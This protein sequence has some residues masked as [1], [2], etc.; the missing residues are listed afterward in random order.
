MINIVPQ[1]PAVL[2]F[3][4]PN[5]YNKNMKH[6]FIINSISG[7]GSGLKIQDMIRKVAEEKQLDHV[8]AL[9][10]RPGHAI[11]LAQQYS[12]PDNIIYCVGGDGT[13]WEVL[14]GIAPGTTLG[15]IPAGSG[16]DFYRLIGPDIS[17]PE[18]ILRD[19]IDAPV[20]QIDIGETQNM[21]F[22][23]TTSFGI[24]ADVNEYASHLIR[25]TVITKG[26]AYIISIIKNLLTLKPK[27]IRINID[28]QE[29]EGNYYIVACMNGRYYGNGVLPAPESDLQDGYF[30]LCLLNEI[31]KRKTLPF[32]ARYMKGKH[33]GYP[34]FEIIHAK[35]IIIDSD[36]DLSCQSDG[37]NYTSKHIELHMKKAWLNLKVPGYLNIIR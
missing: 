27:H 17:D 33:L 1:S 11:Q 36:Q 7:K 34:G 4:D 21:R 10:E 16:N 28:G 2:N 29:H 5:S 31:P 24:D 35:D 3:W 18:K 12:R 20:K 6:V 25:K 13:L 22:L 26:P 32:L 8:I 14:N 30:D 15:I 37:E 9:T 23:N 19:T